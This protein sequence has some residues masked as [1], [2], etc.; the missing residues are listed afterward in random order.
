MTEFT[1]VV[2]RLALWLLPALLGF[3]AMRAWRGGRSRVAA[4]LVL[5][6]LLCGVLVRPIPIG[7]VLLLVGLLAGWGGA[8]RGANR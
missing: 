1:F 6:G 7:L 8:L 3:M 4:G 5:A 2:I